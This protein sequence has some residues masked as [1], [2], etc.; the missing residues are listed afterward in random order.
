MKTC[1]RCLGTG[2]AGIVRCAL[3]RGTGQV[4]G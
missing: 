2:K 1:P 3:C 4:K